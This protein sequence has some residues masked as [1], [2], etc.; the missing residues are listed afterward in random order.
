MIVTLTSTGW[1]LLAG[2][3]ESSKGVLK[4]L[5]IVPALGFALATAWA[6]AIGLVMSSRAAR[7]PDG[8]RWVRRPVVVG[9]A[10]LIVPGLGL[11]LSGRPRLGAWMFGLLAPLAA[12][13]L[14]LA[15]A[16][17]LWTLP[18]PASMSGISRPDLETVFLAATGCTAVILFAWIVQALD[19]IRRVTPAPSSTLSGLVSAGLLVALVLFGVG[20]RPV[21]VA[22]QLHSAGTRFQ[23]DG[24]RVVPLVLSEAA[25]RLDPATP[26]YLSRAAALHGDLGRNEA[27]RARW[28]LLTERARA[29]TAAAR[30]AGRGG[31]AEVVVPALPHEVDRVGTGAETF[32]SG[33]ATLFR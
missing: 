27:A 3:L 4:W 8:V 18:S 26:E 12:C 10:G 5:L 16:P 29:W 20:F 14:V 24:W 25:Y 21:V 32:W 17:R 1:P 23:R 33:I 28:D 11:L 2:T 13:A 22:E 19:G 30:S 7:F 6:R 31:G 9:A 15:H